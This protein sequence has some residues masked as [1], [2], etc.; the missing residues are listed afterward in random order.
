MAGFVLRGAWVAPLWAGTVPV[1]SGTAPT[2]GPGGAGSTHRGLSQCPVPESLSSAEGRRRRAGLW[3]CWKQTGKEGC[4]ALRIISC[5]PEACRQGE[6]PSCAWL[7]GESRPGSWDAAGHLDLSVLSA[8][9]H[10]HSLRWKGLPVPRE[11]CPPPCSLNPC[12]EH[13]N[14]QDPRYAKGLLASP[15]RTS[16][17]PQGAV[18][19]FFLLCAGIAG[20][21]LSPASPLLGTLRW[22]RACDVQ[23]MR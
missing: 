22:R 16:P 5:Q 7:R 3:L 6:K 20:W 10:S 17:L 1:G 19:H 4:V 15:R 9:S 2:P 23:R 18:V 14:G 12:A 21:C 8:G 13:R 11:S